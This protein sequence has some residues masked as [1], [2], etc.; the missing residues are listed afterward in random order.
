[1]HTKLFVV[2]PTSQRSGPRAPLGNE[3]QK[4]AVGTKL[5]KTPQNKQDKT[6]TH[7]QK[8]QI[9]FKHNIREPENNV[10]RIGVLLTPSSAGQCGT[11]PLQTLFMRPRAA[12]CGG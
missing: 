6:N 9:I 10:A 7:Q 3:I 12:P 8:G 2:S 1:M 4:S 11:P 5:K